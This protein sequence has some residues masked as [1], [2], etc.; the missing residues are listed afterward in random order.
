[1]YFVYDFTCF[2]TSSLCRIAQW[3]CDLAH[4]FGK[5]RVCWL[6]LVLGFRYQRLVPGFFGG[7]PALDV[8]A[9]QEEHC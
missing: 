8:P 5:L 1:M 4:T 9:T 3:E 6:D 2:F 7:N